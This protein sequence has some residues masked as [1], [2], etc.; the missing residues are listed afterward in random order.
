MSCIPS[1]PP[2]RLPSTT[3]PTVRPNP[4]PVVLSPGGGGINKANG[5]SNQ[6]ASNNAVTPH[7]TLPVA[8]PKRGSNDVK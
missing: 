2:S 1:G 4:N 3:M 6:Q 8:L 7:R 5:G